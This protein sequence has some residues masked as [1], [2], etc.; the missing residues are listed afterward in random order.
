MLDQAGVDLVTMGNNHAA[1]YGPVGLSDTLRATRTGPIPAVGIGRDRDA[2]FRPYRVSVGDT[3][4]AFLGADSTPREHR[5]GSGARDRTG[6]HRSSPVRD[7]PALLR[8]VRA[9]S[10]R[11][12]V[13]VVYLHWGSG[14]ERCPTVKQQR[15]AR[16]VA[17]AGADVIV[18]ATLTCCSAPAGWGRPT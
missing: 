4:V 16:A 11:D 9:A 6:G 10:E 5:A 18:G 2:A 13:V 1:D 3:D 15:T 12:D 8:A 17:R 14:G 7:S